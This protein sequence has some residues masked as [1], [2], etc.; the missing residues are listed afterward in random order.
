MNKI[1]SKSIK[2][3]LDNILWMLFDKIFILVLN[4]IVTVRV[5]NHY[6][7]LEYGIYQYIIS[8]VA[9]FE[10][11]VTFVDS[12]VIKKRYVSGKFEEIVLNAT[13]T[14]LFF[15][16]LSFVFGTIYLLF[17]N[18]NSKFIL[19]FIIL[20]INTIILNLRFGMQSRYEYLLKAKKVVIA[21]NFALGIGGILQL[22]AVFYNFPI[23]II[24]IITTLTSLIS[25]LVIYIQYRID[26]GRLSQG[27]CNKLL[28]KEL[29]IESLPLAIAASCAIIY[30]KSDSIMIG[31]LLSKESVGIYS[32]AV[33]L[34]H[35]VQIGINPIRE[36]LFPKMIELYN[37]NKEQ[38]AKRYI[39]ITAILTWFYIIGVIVSLFILQFIFRYLN[40]EYAEAFSIYKVYVF[41]TFFMYNAGLRAGH[42]TMINRG[43]IL[44]YAQ[45]V[46]VIINLLLNYFLIQSIGIYG[47]AIAT[48]ITEC[49]SLLISN[50]FFKKEGKEIFLWQVK[51]M[52]PFYIFKK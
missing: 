44:M 47:A 50:L 21:S 42:L 39:Q 41:G 17:N 38:Y 40:P 29:V 16:I 45:I 11:L 46:S 24:A 48:C 22:I 23:I 1:K 28:I 8:I 6:G 36:T 9:L 35:V 15:S 3:I 18:E 13:I 10:I 2:K 30:N 52:N 12:R 27:K 19:I 20:L 4:L 31:N 34:I 33:K 14:R 25:L 32:I 7:S 51:G 5:A 37:R 26:F 43:N 49:I